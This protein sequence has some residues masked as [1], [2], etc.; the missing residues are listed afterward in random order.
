MKALKSW[1]ETHK[2]HIMLPDGSAAMVTSQGCLATGE[3][4]N[5][6]DWFRYYDDVLKKSFSFDPITQAS[7]VL[8]QTME[9]GT[10]ELRENLVKELKAYIDESYKKDKALFQVT[11]GDDESHQ[12]IEI[13]CQNYKLD[14]FW[15][16]EWLTTFVVKNG[17]MSGD[18]KIRC[19]YFEMGNMQFNLDK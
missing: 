11:Q 7:S 18:L 19:H 17:V 2:Y 8:D 15:S 16:G 4:A 12:V 3:E 1:Y 6:I 14:A 13:S 5:P 9:N 10:C